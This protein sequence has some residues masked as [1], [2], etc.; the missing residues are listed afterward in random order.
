MITYKKLIKHAEAQE[1]GV[2]ITS[3]GILE[4]DKENYHLLRERG[5]QSHHLLYILEGTGYIYTGKSIQ[6][7]HSGSAILYYPGQKHEYGYSA[8]E[9]TTVFFCHFSGN[10][11]EEFLNEQP[12]CSEK[13]IRS[14]RFDACH[15][16]INRLTEDNSS[17]SAKALGILSLLYEIYLSEKEEH[18]ADPIDRI[19]SEI[20]DNYTCDTS[21]DEWAQRC[22]C[23]KHHFLRCFKAKTGTSPIAYRNEYRLT[24]ADQLLS[25]TD[26]TLDKIAEAVGFYSASYFS[27]LYKKSRGHSPKAKIDTQQNFKF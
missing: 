2:K 14:A 24:I 19:I 16:I 13:V 7:A 9:K 3:M 23:S 21:I 22:F 17:P 15:N 27:R 12:I 26:L 25:E 8:D 20:H 6:K 11:V 1:L 10:G 18:N 4:F 5:G